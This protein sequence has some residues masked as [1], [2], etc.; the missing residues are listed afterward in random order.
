MNEPLVSVILPFKNNRETIEESVQSILDQTYENLEIITVNDNSTDGS[1]ETVQHFDDQR[2]KIINSTGNGLVDALNSGIRQ[3]RGAFIAR[4]DSD[5][6]SCRERI[7]EQVDYL[8]KNTTIG[9]VSC[10]IEYKGDQDRFHGYFEHVQWLNKLVKPEQIC[11]RR[12]QDSPMAHPSVLFRRSLIDA[13]GGYRKGDFP[14]DYDLWLRWMAMGVRFGKVPKPLLVWRDHAGRLS[15]NHPSYSVDAFFRLK[16]NYLALW[17]RSRRNPPKRIYIWGVGPAVKRKSSWLAAHQIEVAAYIDVTERKL[18]NS[19]PVIHYKN[20][21]R[22]EN[23]LILSYVSDRKGRELIC[24]YLKSH[25][26]IEGRD[27]LLMA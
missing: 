23:N 1:Y 2:L 13:Y 22:N 12:F 26:F 25:G 6:F 24:S 9:V 14:E 21:Q 11:H 27:F 4:M 8:Q 15:R 16:S 5:D 19:K 10:L 20:I 17:L 7:A 18:F 3:S